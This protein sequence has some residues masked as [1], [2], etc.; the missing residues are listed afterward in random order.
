MHRHRAQLALA[1]LSAVS[2][3]FVIAGS[4]S[5]NPLLP[6]LR[7]EVPLAPLAVS[8]TFVA[9][10]GSAVLTLL[11][12]AV[13]PRPLPPAAALVVALLAAAVGDLLLADPTEGRLL[14]GRALTGVAVGL[15]T[16]SAAAL[17]VGALGGRGRGLAATGNLVG[18]VVGTALAQ[19]VAL[20]ASVT[21]AGTMYLAGAA[22][23][24]VLCAALIVLVRV[25]PRV[26]PPAVAAPGG[27]SRP[28]ARRGVVG[29]AVA[30]T[31]LSTAVVYAPILF[32]D[33]GMPGAQLAGTVVMLIA[34]AAA[35]LGSAVLTRIAGR[36]TGFLV[37]AGGIALVAVSILLRSDVLAVAATA[38]I[39]AGAAT[40]YRTALV[41][42]THGSS[43]AR[44][45]RATSSFS[46]ATY[47][48]SALAVL[49]IG[50]LTG[51]L[52]STAV[53]AGTGAVLVVGAL[54]MQPFAPRLR[55]VGA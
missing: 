29:A 51:G 42:L 46:V 25:V 1:A 7:A 10:V 19:L 35:Q 15:A 34:A 21:A 41:H 36:S 50:L 26:P 30:W 8:L 37:L 6:L 16:G 17:V 55:D 49:T 12:V 4:N 54:V 9:Y 22:V 13:A 53:L 11:A 44:Q 32:H 33:A 39:G 43:P 27:S 23:S 2:F 3:G 18:A 48:A 20:L 45:S 24:L 47:S 31:A 28:G 14:A 40:A 5:L 52:D 38:L